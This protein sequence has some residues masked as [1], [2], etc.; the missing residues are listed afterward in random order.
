MLFSHIVAIG[1]VQQNQPD[2]V[3]RTTVVIGE[4]GETGS[5]APRGTGF[6][7]SDGSAVCLMTAQHVISSVKAPIAIKLLVSYVPRILKLDEAAYSSAH[8]GMRPST[9]LAAVRLKPVPNG[10]L[11]V[12][13]RSQIQADTPLPVKERPI[14]VFGFPLGIGSSDFTPVSQE[15]NRACG[16]VEAKSD[17]HPAAAQYYLLDRPSVQGYSGAP[18]FQVPGVFDRGTNLVVGKDLI[19]VG[20]IAGS[21][22]DNTG[23]KLGVAIPPQFIAELF[24]RACAV[25]P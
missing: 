6:L 17:A 8:W 14:V 20:V 13:R 21:L 24:D 12:F 16:S 1:S 15:Y 10:T 2:S 18:A 11:H 7:S 3:A 25:R 4:A 19:L 23:G 9:D 5:L 22:S